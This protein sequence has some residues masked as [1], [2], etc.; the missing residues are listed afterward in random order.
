MQQTYASLEDR[1]APHLSSISVSAS[2][3]PFPDAESVTAVYYPG[4][5]SFAYAGQMA[6]G[7]Y[8]VVGSDLERM[9]YHARQYAAFQD[10]V[11]AFEEIEGDRLRSYLASEGKELAPFLGSFSGSIDSR[12]VA[13]LG[14]SDEGGILF[15]GEHYYPKAVGLLRSY[16]VDLPDREALRA[17]VLFTLVHEYAHNAG[18]HSELEVY[19][20][21]ERYFL[22]RAN[23]TE[24][25]EREMYAQLAGVA[26]KRK[27]EYL[28]GEGSARSSSE[29]N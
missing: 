13:A 24:G 18:M 5:A 11:R 2:P 4:V 9:V 29:S 28:H 15:A 16:G 20:F 12:A 17:G 21:Q 25:E 26:M 19:E 7:G 8:V 27:E 22:D 3:A 23:A 14:I 6:D 10:D 1:I